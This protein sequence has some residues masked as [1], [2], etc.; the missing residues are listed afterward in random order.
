MKIVRT[1]QELAQAYAEIMRHK[2]VGYDL[3]TT[4]LNPKQ[5]RILLVSLTTE[6][7]T[8][9]LDY[10]ALALDTLKTLEP[11][12]TKLFIV[13]ANITFDYKFLF[14]HTGIRIQR[15]TDIMVNEQV[16]TAGKFVPYTGKNPPF[17]LASIAY[18]RLDITLD[19]DVREEFI[20]YKEKQT[21]SQ[22]A[23][24]YA[25]RDT[26]V[27]LPIWEQQ[28]AE[29][30]KHKLERIIND[31]EN[32]LLPVTAHMELTGVLLNVTQLKSLEE[33]FQRYIDTT[34]RVFQDMIIAN[35]G[36]NRIVCDDT[37]YAV[38]MSSKPQV[39]EALNLVGVDT[40]SLDAKAL[41]KWDLK[42]NKDSLEQIELLLRSDEN[43]IHEAIE[44]FGGYNNPYLRAYSFYVGAEKLLG[45]YIKGLQKRVHADGYWY[46]WFRQCGARA[47]GRYSSDAQQVPKD[48]KLQ[49]LGLPY[50]IRECIIAPNGK[51]LIIADFSAIELVILADR[52][53]DTRLVQEI[54]HGDI[55]VVVTQEVMGNF[56]PIAKEI[57]K[58]N[59]KL[60]PYETLR[61]FSKT[62]SYGIA[63]GVTGKSLAEQAATKLS[64]LNLK[65]TAKQG[66]QAVELWKQS[67]P[68][69]GVF[70]NKSA[71][72]AISEGYTDSIWGRKRWF[73]LDYI[74]RDK[75]KLLAAQRE[76]SNQRIQS[77]SADMTKL[78]M[79]YTHNMLNSR[80]AQI[81]LS[82]HDEIVLVSDEDYAE[83]AAYIL[84][85]CMQQAAKDVLVRL[86]DMV[87]VDPSISDRY[88]K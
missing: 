25:G 52:S 76:G 73:D 58:A 43:D 23:Y 13:G 27:L 72:M 20:T 5:D 34:E 33:P 55:H 1:P 41:S 88:D 2:A 19:K 62:L 48:Q 84:K 59:K 74:A 14:W 32:K 45:A 66:D 30:R 61:D 29:I 86:G 35:G 36:A 26:E 51:K 69:A 80:K 21:L 87:I 8:Y 70:L 78:A 50:S 79:I 81:M 63:Y 65:F 12:F 83:Q 67:F 39:I 40:D 71:T 42:K 44:K 82:I 10:T 38:T 16:L 46:P 24:I 7:E 85:H 64:Y 18:R 54:L 22:E 77:T 6:S 17:S 60:Q 28:Q 3:E 37:Y 53:G 56:W 47:T 9:V 15:M 68:Q 31:I 49:N 75:W 4:G 57:T 11:M